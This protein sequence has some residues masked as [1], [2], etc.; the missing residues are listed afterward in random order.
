MRKR[1]LICD[2]AGLARTTLKNILLEA[3]YEIVGEANDGAMAVELYKQ[4]QPEMVFMDI[5]M[6]QM[7]GIEAVSHIMEYDK[8]AFIIMCSSLAQQKKVV[9]AVKAGAKDF[10]V[11]PITSQ[12]VLDTIAKNDV[13]EK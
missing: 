11:K 5:V 10:I 9:N 7:D 6:P 3:G 13:E 2:D 1:V 8:N 4:L 12:R